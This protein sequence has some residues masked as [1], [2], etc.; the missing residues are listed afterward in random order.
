MKNIFRLL[1]S[2]L[3][4][5]IVAF[6]FAACSEDKMDEINYDK[7]T[8]K[9]VEARFIIPDLEL[10]T[11]QY[12]IGGDFNTY[13]GSYVEYWA[14]T[15]NQLY[16][17]ELR[18]AEVRVSSTFNNNWGS[19]FENIRNGKIILEKCDPNT[20]S[21]PGSVQA[22]AIGQT[23][24]A[25]NLAT[26]TD[27]FGDIPYVEV[28]SP[29]EFPYPKADTQQSI[30]AEVM[31]LLD[32]AASNFAKNPSSI[33]SYDFIYGGKNA[34][35]LKL[36]NGLKARYTMRLN[37]RSA[38]LA[39]VIEYADASFESEA[40]NASMQYANTDNQ[41]PM[42]DFEWSR[43]AISSCT[44]MWGKLWERE[45]PRMDRVYWHSGAWVHLGGEDAFDYLAPTG[46]PE[47][48][49]GGYMYDI[50]A[51]SEWAPVHLMSY[52][53][54][55]FLKAEAQAR[56][57]KTAE[58]KET[59]KEAVKGAFENLEVSID[60]AMNSP[61]LNNYGGLDPIEVLSPAESDALAEEYFDGSVSDLFDE[62]PLKE[63]MIQKYIG[64]W[65]ANGETLETY[66]DIRRLK[67]EGK[68]F[69]EL[70]NPGKFPLRCPYG[71]DDV[72]ANPNI[73]PLYTD[74]GN[75]IFTENV[76]WAGGSR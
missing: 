61:S 44:S 59:L 10:R 34:L 13:L 35:W 49:Q 38:D 55:Q 53:E 58:A 56:L 17:A 64:L 20:G 15:H 42:F 3:V 2:A 74:Q 28:G 25:I 50:F 30:Y 68:D 7:D 1:K 39:K 69:Y 60:G 16:Q 47:E 71:N 57:G 45:D 21:E 36:V 70:I 32:A 23:L 43:D 40:E 65:G 26:G 24:L 31:K 54:V 9:D 8:P 51:F 6:S 63:I 14:G 52:H 46:E 19:L 22:L 73:S 12:I 76:W 75:Y 4:L 41:N 62:N 67:A 27:I 48:S 72:V 29:Y 66:A 33:G 18:N 5:S 37:N 11:A